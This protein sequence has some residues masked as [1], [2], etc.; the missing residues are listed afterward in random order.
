[1]KTEFPAN[2][3]QV[4]LHAIDGTHDR[5][6]IAHNVTH[7]EARDMDKYPA[8]VVVR[9]GRKWIYSYSLMDS[10]CKELRK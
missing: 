2:R 9:N 1:M 5:I 6:G 7:D 10:Y 4:F 8:G 3:F